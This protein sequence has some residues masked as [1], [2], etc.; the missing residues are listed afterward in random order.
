MGRVRVAAMSTLFVYVVVVVSALR[1][2]RRSS[3]SLPCTSD[4][5]SLLVADPPAWALPGSF[6][7][8]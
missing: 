5:F 6:G 2:D 4:M 8:G 3:H 1:F 7:L